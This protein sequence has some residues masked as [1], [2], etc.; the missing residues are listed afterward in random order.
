MKPPENRD[1]WI[2]ELRFVP[3]MQQCR[4]E[5]AAMLKGREETGRNMPDMMTAYCGVDCSV[6]T[7]YTGNRCP[8]CR[9]TD[10]KDPDICLPVQCCIKKKISSCGECT[11][12]PCKEMKDFYLE[13]ESHN[14]AYQRL[15]QQRRDAA[16]NH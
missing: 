6:C 16:G 13:S 8:G 7:D 15:L 9:Q 12:F 4:M 3:S 5:P 14:R 10:W 11:L 1:R 2:T